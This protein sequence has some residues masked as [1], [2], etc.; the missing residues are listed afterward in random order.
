MSNEKQLLI[1]RIIS[2][3]IPAY[4]YQ[5]ELEYEKTLTHAI[6]GG[7]LTNQELLVR[8][9]AP[10]DFASEIKKNNAELTKKKQKLYEWRDTPSI[11][12]Y[13]REV[14]ALK[15]AISFLLNEQYKFFTH[16]AEY[17]ATQAKNK[18]IC[19][20]YQVDDIPDRVEESEIRLIARSYEWFSLYSAG[21]QCSV[22]SHE[23]IDLLGW[24]KRYEN[25]RQHP[26]CPEEDVINDDDL[27][28]GWTSYISNKK[29]QD[30]PADGKEVFI[31]AKS[32]QD[33]KRIQDKNSPEAKF[34]IKMRDNKMMKKGEL[35]ENDLPDKQGIIKF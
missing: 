1:S 31:P 25:I 21:F 7:C 5:A 10:I 14:Q 9:G 15:D 23:V 3:T 34:M 33:I 32:P 6:F 24:T 8:L 16:S 12:E 13:R 2:S 30:D 28:D 20:K 18:F 4:D 29:R 35:N 26:D 17:I 11:V 27:L 22:F 19:A